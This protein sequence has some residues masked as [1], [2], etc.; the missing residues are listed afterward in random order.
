MYPQTTAD[1]IVS[2]IETASTCKS[3]EPRRDDDSASSDPSISPLSKACD[4][5]ALL[6]NGML[7]AGALSNLVPNPEI[8]PVPSMTMRGPPSS[9]FFL[10]SVRL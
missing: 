3:I 7:E 2:T 4:V 8:E 6:E 9:D 5:V 10:R 1:F